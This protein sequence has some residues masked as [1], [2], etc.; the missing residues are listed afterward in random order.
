MVQ[1]EVVRVLVHGS[2]M[3][4]NEVTSIGNVNLHEG[5]MKSTDIHLDDS[6]LS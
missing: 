2:A 4:C 6:N 5:L 1:L 3:I